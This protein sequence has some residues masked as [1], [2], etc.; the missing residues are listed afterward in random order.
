MSVPQHRIGM[1]HALSP[2]AASK[3]A[4]HA[5]VSL[6]TFWDRKRERRDKRRAAR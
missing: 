2:L 6:C 3:I 5:N 1:T 4:K